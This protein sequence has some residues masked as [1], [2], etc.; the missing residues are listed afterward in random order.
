MLLRNFILI[1]ILT[2]TVNAFAK[3]VTETF[4][5]DSR[6]SSSDLVW[7]TALGLLHP[8]LEVSTWSSDGITFDSTDID[9]GDG[10]DG[11]FV[12][13]RYSQFSEN[14]DVS[15]NTIRINTDD[16]PELNFTEFTL[17]STW[18][19]EPVG[20]G[21]LI[22]RVLGDVTIHGT[23]N[24]AGNDGG[25]DSADPT[26]VISGGAGRCGGGDGGDS[27]VAGNSPGIAN[28]G[29]AGGTFVTGG[30]GGAAADGSGGYGGGGGGSYVKTY[31]G[32]GDDPDPTNGRSGLAAFTGG[33]FGTIHRDD[34]FADDLNGAGSGGGGGSGFDGTATEDSSGASG[35]GGG[36]T[37]RIYSAGNITV[38]ATGYI[39]ANGGS[40][41][42]VM[43]NLRKGGAGGGGGGGSILLFAAGTMTNNNVISA[44]AGSAGITIAAG[45]GSHG[46][47]GAWGRTWVNDADSTPSGVPEVPQTRLDVPG[48]IA[49]KTGTNYEA[50]SKVFDLG[51][52]KPQWTTLLAT[53]NNLGAS[54]VVFEAA[55]SDSTSISSF[56]AFQDASLFVGNTSLRYAR[57]RVA[58]NNDVANNL[59]PTTVSQLDFIFDPHI[60]DEYNF[61]T[62]CGGAKSTAQFKPTNIEHL[63]NFFSLSPQQASH[64]SIILML[65]LLPFMALYHS[66][67]K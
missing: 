23:I 28:K 26:S 67:P 61:T 3:T 57:F 8:P 41:G 54:N 17:D 50:I 18:T 44:Q 25:D 64:G 45:S 47:D 62:G 10:H 9:V 15:G 11:A 42:N 65:L 52:T 38:S 33:N 43:N 2:M 40:G 29:A 7:N 14:G 19:I 22:I 27:V 36:G 60:Q 48:F 24:C 21:P 6:K 31:A 53:I 39:N 46:G 32:I 20:G 49:Y 30:D 4:S 66:R 34:E 56:P 35:G 12:L 1:I 13:N 51:N 59:I 55:F 5:T 63:S 16:W 37:I 58:I